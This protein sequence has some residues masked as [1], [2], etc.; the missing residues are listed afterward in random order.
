[1]R[2][3][4][5]IAAILVVAAGAFLCWWMHR[6]SD[7][8]LIDELVA[9]AEHGIETKSLDEIMGCIAPDYQDPTGLSKLEVYRGAMHFVQSPDTADVSID[10]TSVEIT[11]PTATGVFDVHV[12]ITQNGRYI[13]S[14]PMQVTVQFEKERRRLSKVWMVKSVSAPGISRQFE[15]YM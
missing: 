11:S 6:A 3:R 5:W 8:Q 12:V 7:R 9:R 10:N 13:D 2:K 15:D 4:L 1:V 14:G